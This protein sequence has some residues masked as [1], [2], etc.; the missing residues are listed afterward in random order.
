MTSG[1]RGELTDG[2]EN[3]S[4][5]HGI[6][7]RPCAQVVELGAVH[8]KVDPVGAEFDSGDLDDVRSDDEREKTGA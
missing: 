2:P 7:R 6:R 5:P 3:I 1:K 4:R 8:G